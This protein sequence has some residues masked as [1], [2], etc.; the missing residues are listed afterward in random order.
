MSFGF[1][2]L[3]KTL[4]LNYVL[5]CYVNHS[6]VMPASL[7]FVLYLSLNN[8]MY[9]NRWQLIV[10]SDSQEILRLLWKQNVHDRINKSRPCFQV[11]KQEGSVRVYHVSNIK[12]TLPSHQCPRLPDTL[13]SQGSRDCNHIRPPY[14]HHACYTY[15]QLIHCDSIA[16]IPFSKG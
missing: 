8:S 11:L 2:G 15:N 6:F 4:F 12:L 7:T 3:I 9:Q 14:S 13:F 16:L 1:K 10:R 5:Y